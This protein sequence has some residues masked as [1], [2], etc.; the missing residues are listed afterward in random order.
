MSFQRI[1]D[2]LERSP[3]TGAQAVQVARMGFLHWACGVEGPVTTQM[4]RAALDCPAA[5]AAESD[6]ARAFVGVLQEASR[7]CLARPMRRC[8]ARVVH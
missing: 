2:G 6:A 7:M 3:A 5:Q 8:R 4:V 1:M